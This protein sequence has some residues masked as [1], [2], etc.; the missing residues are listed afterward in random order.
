MEK[1]MKGEWR[2]EDSMKNLGKASLGKAALIFLIS[3]VMGVSLTMAGSKGSSGGQFLRIGV[4]AR[5]P[6]MGGAFSPI[7]DDAT[8]IYWNPAGMSMMDKR[9]LSLAYNAYFKDTA[10]QFLGYA[11]PTENHGTFGTGVSLFGVNNIEK[12]SATAG[13]ADTPDLGT[14]NTRDMAIA[15]GWANKVSL[16]NGLMRYGLSLK[17]ISS[18]L[19]TATAKTYAVD[20][21]VIHNLNADG[22][23]LSA[24]LAILNLGGKL[25]F[26]DEGDALPLNIKPG[27]AWRGDLGRAG[28]LN[29]VVDTDLLVHD[30]LAYVEEGLE[31]WVHPMFALR[32]GY[33][34]GRGKGAGNGLGVGVGFRIM[35]VGLDY[36]F[37]PYGDLGDTHRI[38]LDFKF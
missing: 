20:L 26:Q 2:R 34:F 38:S 3:F 23:G 25:K 33:Q 28:K 14:F 5:G 11:H 30:G 6:A 4:G 35:N 16:M 10:S 13:D 29:A 12:R 32:S 37:V 15:L 22:M 36:A 8:A 18:N 21:G 17:Y 24:S 31:W 19:N 9:D 7:A 1:N 27:L